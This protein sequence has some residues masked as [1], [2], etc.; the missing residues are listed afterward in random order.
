MGDDAR[1]GQLATACNAEKMKQ[2]IAKDCQNMICDVADSTDNS[3]M[4][5]H[6]IL[7]QNLKMKKVCSKLVLKVMM[8]EQKK[9]RIFIAETFLNDC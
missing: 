8:L 4:N 9:E 1:T 7:R 3:C 2:E 6:K 5:A